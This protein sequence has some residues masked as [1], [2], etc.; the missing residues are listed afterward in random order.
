MI[1]W[2]GIRG[3]GSL[4]YLM[5]TLEQGPRAELLPLVPWVLAIVAVSIV[6]HGI[7][8][9]RSCAASREIQSGRGACLGRTVRRDTTPGTQGAGGRLSM[10]LQRR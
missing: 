5:L 8:P 6:L 9:R 7:Q 10:N 1:S 3:V 2:F 4:Y